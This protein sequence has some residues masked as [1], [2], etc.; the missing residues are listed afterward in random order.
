MGCIGNR[1]TLS[2]L[3][4]AGT[5]YVAIEGKDFYVSL[6]SGAIYNK[7]DDSQRFDNPV[8]VGL[9]MD[10]VWQEYDKQNKP[11]QKPQPTKAYIIVNLETGE[12]VSVFDNRSD[13]EDEA[14]ILNEDEGLLDD[15]GEVEEPMYDV[16]VFI[17]RD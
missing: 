6:N 7:K 15:D 9:A 2:N 16:Q 1:E 13:A 17:P 4:R 10:Q 3:R 11:V 14:Q 5:H 12:L 8:T